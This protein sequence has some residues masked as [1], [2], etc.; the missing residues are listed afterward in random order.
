MRRRGVGAAACMPSYVAVAIC[1]G[2]EKIGDLPITLAGTREE[3]QVRWTHA[4][5]LMLVDVK[6]LLAWA[7]RVGREG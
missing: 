7:F 5:K 3:P 6:W 1:A 2:G 4:L